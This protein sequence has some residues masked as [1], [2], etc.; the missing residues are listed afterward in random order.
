MLTDGDPATTRSVLQLLEDSGHQVEV[1]SDGVESLQRLFQ[2]RPDLV[3]IDVW[4]PGVLGW[5][6]C[7]RIREVTGIPLLILKSKG[8]DATEL[9]ALAWGADLCVDKPF[10]PA[11]LLA[12]AHALIRRWRLAGM[13][14]QQAVTVGSLQINLDRHEV[15]LAGKPLDLSPTEFRLLS[16]L[17]ARP[18]QVVPHRELLSEVWGS[19]YSAEDV[20][21]KLYICYLRQ[22]IEDDPSQPQY[23]LTKR[24]VGYCLNDRVSLM[25]ARGA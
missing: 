9:Q 1:A 4:K 8:D 16:A 17:A 13:A 7:R 11:L 21:L 14:G 12:R 23:I 2:F 6:L 18:G 25:E 15:T 19:E 3:I 10:S 22:K 20:Y 24:G 5:E